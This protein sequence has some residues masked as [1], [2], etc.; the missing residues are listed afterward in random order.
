MGVCLSTA[1][2]SDLHA[3]GL[4]NKNYLLLANLVNYC[5]LVLRPSDSA[6]WERAK[7]CMR[8]C[9]GAQDRAGDVKEMKG[10]E[11]SGTARG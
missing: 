7:T 4:N 1:V 6:R 11:A 2:P 9:K 3:R 10:R 5:S 8:L